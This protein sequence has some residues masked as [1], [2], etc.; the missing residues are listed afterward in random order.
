ML[1]LEHKTCTLRIVSG[2]QM[3]H[4]YLRRGRLISARTGPLQDQPAALSILDWPNCTISISEGAS[5]S[6]TMDLSIQTLLMEWCINRDE[7]EQPPPPARREKA[8]H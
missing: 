7:N 5:V 6:E 2:Y 4:L 1:E 8:T 3:G